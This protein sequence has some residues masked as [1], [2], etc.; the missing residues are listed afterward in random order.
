[1]W[2]TFYTQAGLEDGLSYLG[3]KPGLWNLLKKMLHPKPKR[4]FSSQQS[5]TKATE[6]LSASNSFTVEDRIANDGKYFNLVLQDLDICTLSDM[7]ETT[8]VALDE[9]ST[10]D[11]RPLHYLA[12]FYRD[13]PLG[14]VL[15]EVDAVDED[16]SYEHEEQWKTA[17]VSA[18][19][20]DVFVRDVVPGGQADKMGIFE[21]GDR[22]A[23]VNEFPH[24]G[25]FESFV[26]MLQAVPD[27]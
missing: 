26:G 24:T 7:T 19:P 22:L 18:K 25:G 8:E 10:L 17:V 12:T 6:I 16:E 9:M 1:M 14:L 20:G 3:G 2:L 15:S 13:E 5:L 11:P 4:R 23:G 21:I 27:R